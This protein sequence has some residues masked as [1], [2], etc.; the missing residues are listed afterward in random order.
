ATVETASAIPPSRRAHA[1]NRAFASAPGNHRSRRRL[2]PY[3]C[4]RRDNIRWHSCDGMDT[5]HQL[6]FV[7]RLAHVIVSAE[8]ETLYLV[9]DCG[10]PGED[11]NGR[12]HGRRARAC[13]D[14]LMPRKRL[15]GVELDSQFEL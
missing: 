5:R 13:P 7:E 11:Q 12:P 6:I 8:A 14:G 3:R 4:Q 9:L 10:K 1:D 15:G 2:H